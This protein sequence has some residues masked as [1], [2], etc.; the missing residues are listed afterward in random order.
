MSRRSITNDANFSHR[1]SISYT[2]LSIKANVQ[3]DHLSRSLQVEGILQTRQGA[4]LRWRKKHGEKPLVINI[5]H[6]SARKPAPAPVTSSI[7]YAEFQ[8]NML[9]IWM[10]V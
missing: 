8:K 7:S 6:A 4:H 5:T 1:Q 10:P 2:L 9:L 3:K